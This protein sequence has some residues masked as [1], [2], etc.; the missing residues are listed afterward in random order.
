MPYFSRTLFFRFTLCFIVLILTA[1]NEPTIHWRVVHVSGH[2]QSGDA[3]IL[4]FPSGK[5][6]MLDTGFAHY[7]N[8]YL[9]PALQEQKITSI[10]KLLISHAHRN[11]YGAIPKLLEQFQIDEVFF[12]L[13]PADSCRKEIWHTGCSMEHI[14]S[15]Q[16]LI[17]E[18]SSLKNIAEGDLIY[19][20]KD[21]SLKALYY[22]DKAPS[23]IPGIGVNDASIVFKLEFGE[24]SVLFTGDLGPSA[25]HYIL[26]K[27]S[28][29][30]SKL[31]STAMTAPH[32]GVAATVTNDFFDQVQPEIVIASIS[33]SVWD[34]DRGKQ[35]REYFQQK[36]TPIYV[37]GEIGNIDIT[38]TKK[39]IEIEQ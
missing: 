20:E 16:K 6:I 19:Q 10:D 27:T 8:R 22:L 3:H 37:T 33:K 12:N 25:S 36:K 14:L 21:I 28:D 13:P 29:S 1:C 32:H 5:T 34:S 26:K 31:K 11:H 39:K 30:A 38:I 23:I 15:V 4:K 9:I 17:K 18:K 7:A 24:T 35:T 2:N